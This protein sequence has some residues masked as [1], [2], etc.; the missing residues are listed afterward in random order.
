MEAGHWPFFE[1]LLGLLH[2]RASEF[3]EEKTLIK[4]T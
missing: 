2:L 1:V 4:P 3:S